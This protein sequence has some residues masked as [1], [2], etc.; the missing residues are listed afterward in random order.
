M[1]ERFGVAPFSVLNAREGWWQERKRAWIG[2]GIR[3]ELGR[4]EKLIFSQSAQPVE[5]Y[6]A[7][8]AYEAKVGRVVSWDEF[9]ENNPDVRVQEGTSIFDP[10]LCE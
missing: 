9:Y 5:V 3:S 7:K 8:N 6:Q 10:V 4:A 1:S 2:L